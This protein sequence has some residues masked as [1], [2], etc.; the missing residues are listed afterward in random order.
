MRAE[1]L[2]LRQKKPSCRY[3]NRSYWL[4]V[5]FKVIQSRQFLFHLKGRMSYFLLL[6]NRNIGRISHCS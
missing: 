6:I 2:Q 4:S 3:D 5:I 1:L